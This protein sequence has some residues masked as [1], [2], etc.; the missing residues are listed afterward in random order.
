M[1][2]ERLDG[3]YSGRFRLDLPGRQYIAV[4][5]IAVDAEASR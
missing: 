3:T 2:I 5:L 1:T 4:R